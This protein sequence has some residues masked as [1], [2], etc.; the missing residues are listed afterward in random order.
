MTMRFIRAFVS[1]AATIA[2]LASTPFAPAAAQSTTSLTKSGTA[3]TPVLTQKINAYIGC[4][5][6][7]SERSYLSRSRYFSWAAKSGPTGKERIIY[8]TYTIYDTSDC[9]RNVEKVNALEPREPELEAAA[10]AFVEAVTA[11]E[12]LLKEADDYY[13]QQDYK[14]DRMAKG[15]AL[16]PRLVAAW[17]AFA[18]ADERLRD[19]IDEIQDKQAR[20]RLAEI[21]KTEGIKDRYHIEAIMLTA[22]YVMRAQKASP[23]DIGALTAAVSDYEAIVKA[24]DEYTGANKDAKIGS[25]FVRDAKTFLTTAKMLMRRVRDKTPYSQGDRM[26]IDSGG[27]A[28]MVEGSPARLTRDYNQLVGS[29]NSGARF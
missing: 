25:S 15:R 22:K 28:W 18:K 13:Q 4:I 5:N 23:P 12:P 1:V 19:D 3:E 29:Y 7:L 27:G 21:E 16:H 10:T 24:T 8:G 9:K 2:L 26:L 20:T 6:R 17:N 14:D 11:L